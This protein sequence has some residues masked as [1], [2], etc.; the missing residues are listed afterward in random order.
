LGLRRISPP[1][2]LHTIAHRRP[3]P[4]PV[5]YSPSDISIPYC[6][7]GDVLRSTYRTDSPVMHHSPLSYSSSTNIAAPCLCVSRLH[8]LF[9]SAFVPDSV[10]D[11]VTYFWTD[12]PYTIYHLGI[13]CDARDTLIL[14][15]WFLIHQLPLAEGEHPFPSPRQVGLTCFVLGIRRSLRLGCQTKLWTPSFLVFFI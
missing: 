11:R 4:A 13:H 15:V 8:C 10:Y 7:R 12:S 3:I 5:H 1:N 9:I 6:D 2:S 14:L